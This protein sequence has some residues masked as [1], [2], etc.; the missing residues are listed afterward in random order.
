MRARHGRAVA[1]GQASTIHF[2][3]KPCSGGKAAA[4]HQLY[5]ER[6]EACVASFGNIAEEES[7]R[8]RVWNEIEGRGAQR[9][10]SIVI[11]AQAPQ[12]LREDAWNRL[13]TW[14]D[15]CR[16]P[17]RLAAQMLRVGPEHWPTD[18]LRIWTHDDADHKRIAQWVREWENTHGS[19]DDESPDAGREARDEEEETTPNEAQGTLPGYEPPPGANAPSEAERKR[20]KEER[21]HKAAKA[22][23]LPRGCRE[24][25]PRRTM[26][27]RRI[28]IELAHELSLEAQ[29]RALR[30]WCEWKLAAHGIS[31]H[32][33]IHQPEAK[34]D[35]RN[36]HAH[37]VVAP[38]TL[39][40][41]R[42]RYGIETGRFTF[43]SQSRL[44]PM[45]KLLRALGGNGP[46]GR[47]GAGQ[48]VKQWRRSLC[49][50]RPERGGAL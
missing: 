45:P 42:S 10:G 28:V 25:L 15:E 46:N 40:R 49:E 8:V 50:I 31:Y 2:A 18:G 48:V 26:V 1:P 20:K 3:L 30:T 47:R 13:Q 34:N 32:A 16:I 19:Q 44:P 5:I 21:R 4:D 24:F 35:V 36:W 11:G 6:E 39:E 38:I 37:V 12:A 17:P 14:R 7:E 43:E 9:K 41:E 22:R 33:V 27:Q 23:K 29:E